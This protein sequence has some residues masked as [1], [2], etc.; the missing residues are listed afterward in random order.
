MHNIKC[1]SNLILLLL[2]FFL[3]TY[4]IN[5]H[6]PLFSEDSRPPILQAVY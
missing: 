3:K 2:L 1:L 5:P 6:K 4:L